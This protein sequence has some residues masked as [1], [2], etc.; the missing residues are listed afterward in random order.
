M[1]RVCYQQGMTGKQPTKSVRLQMV[2][3]PEE[4]LEVDEWRRRQADLPSRSEAI[5]R[6]IQLGLKLDKRDRK[7]PLSDR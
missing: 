3:S 1:Q 7:A 6:L 2:I 5:R 4:I